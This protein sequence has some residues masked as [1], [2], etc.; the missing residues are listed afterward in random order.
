MAVSCELDRLFLLGVVDGG[1]F[2]A[3]LAALFLMFGPTYL[4]VGDNI[5][6]YWVFLRSYEAEQCGDN[7]L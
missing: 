7:N 2:T 1:E 3:P 5:L 4:R 6:A